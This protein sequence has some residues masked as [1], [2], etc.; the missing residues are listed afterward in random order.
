MVFV[1]QKFDVVI[2]GGGIL[3][4][5]ISYWIS[6]LTNHT[7]CVIEK[8][9]HI[10]A[11]ASSRNTGVVHSP[12]YLDPQK[13]KKIAKASL[14]SHDL[15]KDY[16]KKHH[17][18]WKDTGTIEIAMDESQHHTLD[19]G[20]SDEFSPALEI[21]PTSEIKKLDYLVV[22]HPHQDHITDL[23][24]FDKKFDIRV[25][26]RNKKIT[27]DVM[28]KDNP[29]VF[30]PPNDVIINKYYEINNRFITPVEPINDPTTAA[31]GN[32]C[33]LHV[34]YNEDTQLE[35]NDLSIATFI[36]FGN[37]TIL[38]GGDLKEKGWLELLKDNRFR[39]FL[40]TTTILVASHH[41]NESGYCEDIFKHFC[42]KITIF[43]AG[44]YQDFAISKYREKTKGMIVNKRSGGQEK[45]YVLTTRNDGH[46]DLVLYPTFLEPTIRID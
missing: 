28:L 4:T 41:G 19:C 9:D 33:T 13:K 26:S 15:W 11:H 21:N 3:G 2:I 18:S 39:E 8:E 35:V 45:R 23:E 7:V 36:K 38:Y 44:S 43:S 25:M 6:S 37:E 30:D 12:F 14:L 34:F 27:K 1:L 17:I 20:S 16:A 32:G 22:S 29:D 40:K 5:S 42:P 31:W 24:N 46:I 10:A